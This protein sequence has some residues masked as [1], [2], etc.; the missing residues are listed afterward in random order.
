MTADSTGANPPAG[1]WPSPLEPDTIT[2]QRADPRLPVRSGEHVYAL[3][4]EPSRGG[5]SLLW[6]LDREGAWQCVTPDP[7]DVRTRVHE[8]GGRCHLI[9]GQDCWFVHF[10]DQR[11]YHQRLPA[12]DVAVRGVESTLDPPVAVTAAPVVGEGWMLAEPVLH[13]YGRWLIAVGEQRAEAPEAHRNAIVA[14]DLSVQGES[15]PIRVLVDGHDFYAAPRLSDDGRRLAWIAWNMPDMPWQTARLE[16]GDFDAT[17]ARVDAIVHIDGGGTSAVCQPRFD[18]QGAL[19]YVRDEDAAPGTAADHGNVYRHDRTGIVAMTAEALDFGSPHWQFGQ[20]RLVRASD[21]MLAVATGIGGERLLHIGTDGRQRRLLD[22][23]WLGFA[24]LASSADGRVLAIAR[25]VGRRASLLEVDVDSGSAI[26]RHRGE[27]PLPEAF[28]SPAAPYAAIARDG[29]TVHAWHYAPRHARHRLL[30]DERPPAMVLVHG[31]PTSR[32][33]PG[34]ALEH[35]F[36]TTR[37]FAV[38]DIDHR[39]S[40]GHGRHYRQA[41]DGRWGVLDVDDVVDVV[42]EAVASGDIDGERVCIRGGSAGGYVV[43]VA[44]TRYPDVF[45]AGACYYGIGNLGT[46]AESTHKFERRYLDSLLGE[47]HEPARA[48]ADHSVYRQRSPVNWLERLRSPLI[49][50]Q[51]DEDRVVPP[52]VSREL[53]AALARRGIAHEYVEYAGEGHGFRRADNRADALRREAQF[54]LDVLAEP[55][56]AFRR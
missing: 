20:D 29:E 56:H 23:T 27:A 39:G 26:V 22:D 14:V 51:G 25:S 7:F 2:G 55:G 43:L 46:L 52:E 35:Q 45:R 34:F 15:R 6:R 31:G 12:P 36:W 28:V 24:D 48:E 53:V 44:L 17:E 18:R 8:Y 47:V 37:G 41:L 3:R 11:L 4:A 42:R 38:L 1:F 30:R 50:F 13:P 54:L 49:V 16:A 10:A 19:W 9:Q 40:T 5:R 33:T 32:T 21:G